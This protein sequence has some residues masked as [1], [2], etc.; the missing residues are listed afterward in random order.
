MNILIL[1]GQTLLDSEVQRVIGSIDV[2]RPKAIYYK[3]VNIET[4]GDETLRTESRELHRTS[5]VL[6]KLHK[7][8]LSDKTQKKASW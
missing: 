7:L 2:C 1:S 8:Q 6:T 3:L 4:Y 5:S